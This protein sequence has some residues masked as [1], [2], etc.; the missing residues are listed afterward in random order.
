LNDRRLKEVKHGPLGY[1]LH[2]LW[3]SV[4]WDSSVGT[5]T[6]YRLD[7][8]GIESR[9]GWDF[10]HLS[11]LALGPSQPFVQLVPGLSWG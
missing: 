1:T 9:W 4:G 10:P 8:P 2:T 11:R 7:S 6:R 3:H 5:A